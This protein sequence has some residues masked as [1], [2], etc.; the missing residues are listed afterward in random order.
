MQNNTNP[1]FY[2]G[3]L[4]WNLTENP[5]HLF[6]CARVGKLEHTKTYLLLLICAVVGKLKAIYLRVCCQTQPKTKVFYPYGKV[7]KRKQNNV[8]SRKI[9]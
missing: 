1:I 6:I 4:K 9:E 2:K 8:K 5:A 3:F 7:T